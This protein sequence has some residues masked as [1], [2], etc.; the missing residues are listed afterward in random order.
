ARPYLAFELG[1]DEIER[2]G[3]GGDDPVAVEAS[4]AEWAHPA[5]IAE[6]DQ[7]PL[8]ERDDGEGPVELADRGGNGVAERAG[9][10]GDQR[11]DHLRIRGRREPVTLGSELLAELGGVREVAVVAQ[12]DRACAAVLDERLRV[13]PF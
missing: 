13:P 7:F 5:R 6:G 11:C 3:L 4:E 1:A 2:T 12:V 9:F 8:T 10:V